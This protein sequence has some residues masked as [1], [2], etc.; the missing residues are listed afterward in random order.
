MTDEVATTTP[1]VCEIR[2]R[3]QLLGLFR[4]AMPGDV[5]LPE[6]L[7]KDAAYAAAERMGA[8]AV[9]NEGERS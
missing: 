4:S 6:R 2:W 1:H 7:S 9:L 8:V 5:D 3:G